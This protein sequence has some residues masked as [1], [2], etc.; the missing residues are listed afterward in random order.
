MS[1]KRLFILFLRI[2]AFTFGGG[3]VMLGFI[4]KELSLTGC[5]SD[6]EIADMMVLSTALPGPVA[7]SLSYIVGRR[8]A[9]VPGAIT[10]VTGTVIAPFLT[11]LLLSGVL[12]RYVNE[13][14]VSAFFLGASCAVAVIIGRVVWSIASLSCKE[15]WKNF[16]TLALTG[17]MILLADAHPFVALV[18]GVFFRLLV[19]DGRRGSS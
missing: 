4:Q 2:G 6:E 5:L 7:V 17:G 12:L 14:R 8:I 19:A 16:A 1:V 3:I 10:A 15:G 11:I 18:A 13:P 9:G